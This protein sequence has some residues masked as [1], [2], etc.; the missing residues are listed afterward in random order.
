MAGS[1]TDK[2]AADPA[3]EA[4]EV[5]VETG[6]ALATVCR[7]GQR[8]PVHGLR[9]AGSDG[10]RRAASDASLIMFKRLVLPTPQGRRAPR[11]HRDSHPVP[12]RAE[13][14]VFAKVAGSS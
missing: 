10:V 12:R 13:A 5:S 8:S 4:A 9:Q 11:R 7:A 6:V 1:S 3:Q 2:G 14:T